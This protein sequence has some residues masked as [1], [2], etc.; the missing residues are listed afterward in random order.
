MTTT[1]ATPIWLGA[2][3]AVIEW[4]T[5][6]GTASD[7]K[8]GTTT[9]A[10]IGKRDVVLAN[11]SR[12]NVHTLS[13]RVGGTWGDTWYLSAP[14][15]PKA[16]AALHTVRRRNAAHLAGNAL[17]KWAETGDDAHAREALDAISFV[18]NSTITPEVQLHHHPG[19]PPVSDEDRP[20]MAKKTDE[21]ADYDEDYDAEQRPTRRECEADEAQ[22]E[23]EAQS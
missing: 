15:D 12:Y 8:A 2:G 21:T 11:G 13:R 4:T 19:G 1:Q 17:R 6:Y 20:A 18:L 3:R 14:D 10:K 9:V 23:R 5:G 7:T 16:V 22:D